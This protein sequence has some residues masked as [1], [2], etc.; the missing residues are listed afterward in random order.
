MPLCSG[1]R[2]LASKW[3]SFL[4]SAS[5][6]APVSEV[7]SY[8]KLFEIFLGPSNVMFIV[9]ADISYEFFNRSNSNAIRFRKISFVKEF[10]DFFRKV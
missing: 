7:W 3:R 6:T 9:H 8:L 2:P 4:A 1:V 5:K 10:I